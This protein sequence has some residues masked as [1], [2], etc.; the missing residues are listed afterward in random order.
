MTADESGA[1]GDEYAHHSVS[2]LKY[3]VYHAIYSGKRN[4]KMEKSGLDMDLSINLLFPQIGFEKKD[5]RVYIVVLFAGAD[6][7]NGPRS[8]KDANFYTSKFFKIWR[9]HGEEN[10]DHRREL[11]GGVRGLRVQRSCGDLS[12]HPVFD[13]GRVR[14]HLGQPGAQEHVRSEAGSR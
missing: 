7:Y 9:N 14:R 12:D 10:A 13:D 8:V 1:A 4:R 11:R 3:T 2:F 6:I 5:N